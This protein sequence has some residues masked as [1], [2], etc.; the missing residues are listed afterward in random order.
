MKQLTNTKA[1]KLTQDR[2]EF[3][4]KTGSLSVMSLFG[5]SFFTACSSSEDMDPSS[6]DDSG[7]DDSGNGI[8]VSGGTVTI[9]LSK[10][11]GLK[12]NGGWLLV[13][14]ARVLVVNI[15]N[16]MFSALTSVCTHSN[17]ADNWKFQSSQFV[18]G[19][20]GSR[21]TTDGSV[22]NGPAS[23]PLTSYSTMLQDDILTIM[24]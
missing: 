24:K 5:M 7:G 10:Q 17:C 12:T 18:C 16:D 6:P 3:L 13:S 23:S 9:D 1:G 2:R 21:F 4:L 11:S 8:E 19:C 14:E 22:A 20:H 15:G